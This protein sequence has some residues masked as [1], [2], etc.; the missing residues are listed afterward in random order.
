MKKIT[1]TLFVLLFAAS[2]FA[3][4]LDTLIEVGQSMGDIAK[5]SN[6]ETRN[7]EGVKRAIERG[8]LKAG[9][10][11]DSIRKKYGDP[12]VDFPKDANGPEKWVYKPASSSYFEGIKI[13]LY[14][15]DSGNLKETKTINKEKKP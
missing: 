1:I 13:Y 8:S 11:K 12:V 2:A 5:E 3:E 4:G 9:E 14:F 7:F 6:E 10:A 15:D